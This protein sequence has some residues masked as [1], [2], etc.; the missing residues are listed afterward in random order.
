M[1][2]TL[3]ILAWLA[4]PAIAV[5]LG[6]MFYVPRFRAAHRDPVPPAPGD[7]LAARRVLRTGVTRSRLGASRRSA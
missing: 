5:G 7:E 2:A 4:V 6:V 3:I 1:T